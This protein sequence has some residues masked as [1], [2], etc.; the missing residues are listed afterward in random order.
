MSTIS[1]INTATSGIQQNV[2]QLDAAATTVGGPS[3]SPEMLRDLM[4]M[5]QAKLGAS[6]NTKVVAASDRVLGHIVNLTA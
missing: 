2:H 1:A 5:K 6:A 3:F 4:Q